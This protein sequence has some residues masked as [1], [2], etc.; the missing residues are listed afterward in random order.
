MYSFTGTELDLW[1]QASKHHKGGP[2]RCAKLWRDGGLEEGA[3]MPTQ[4][5]SL[6]EW[7]VMGA[8]LVALI[9]WGIYSVVTI[10]Q[11]VIRKRQLSWVRKAAAVLFGTMVVVS[12]FYKPKTPEQI[13]AETQAGEDAHLNLMACVNTEEA[14]QKRLKAPT[15]AKFPGCSAYTVKTNDARTEFFVTGYVDA[16]NSFGAMIRTRFSVAMTKGKTDDSWKVVN[17]LL[18]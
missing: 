1:R 6:W 18:E 10:F 4:D 16:Q 11:W 8:F 9:G 5:L 13:A 7:I 14:V 15:S 12:I 2:D 3:D 17:A